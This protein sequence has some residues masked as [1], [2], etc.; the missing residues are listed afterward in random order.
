MRAQLSF[1]LSEIT[2]LTDGQTEFLS[3]D[4]VCIPCSAV[5]SAPGFQLTLPMLNHAY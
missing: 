3:L 1:I 2:R 5:M 4:R